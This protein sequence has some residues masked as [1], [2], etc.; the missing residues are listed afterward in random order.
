PDRPLLVRQAPILLAVA[1]V[2]VVSNASVWRRVRAIVAL[3][4]AREAQAK[5]EAARLAAGGATVPPAN[6]T[7]ALNGHGP[8]AAGGAAR[9]RALAPRLRRSD[10]QASGRRV[11]RVVHVSRPRGSGRARRDQSARPRAASAAA[12]F[13]RGRSRRERLA[14]GKVAHRQVR[15]RQLLGGLS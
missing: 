9:D 10:Q 12:L 15:V 4:R 7:A 1:I 2:A 3:I 8:A 5:L 6:G 13:R 11:G 14:P